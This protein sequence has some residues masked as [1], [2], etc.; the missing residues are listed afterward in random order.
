MPAE[1]RK[2]ARHRHADHRHMLEELHV[3]RLAKQPEASE[4]GQQHQRQ[5]LVTLDRPAQ[6]A[7][8]Q[9]AEKKAERQDE[10]AVMVGD[11]IPPDLAHRSPGRGERYSDHQINNRQEHQSDA[12]GRCFVIGGPSRLANDTGS[13]CQIFT[14]IS[15]FVLLLLTSGM[16]SAES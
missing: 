14:A 16:L 7:T 11:R 10:K 5:R 9:P 3:T 2:R 15:N 8:L 1:H 6:R 13:F 12:H 4:T